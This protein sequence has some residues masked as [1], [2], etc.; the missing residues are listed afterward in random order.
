[1]RLILIHAGDLRAFAMPWSRLL[2][3][4]LVVFHAC[5]VGF[6]VFGLLA[7]LVG[8]VLRRDWVRNFWF[9]MVHLVMIGIVVVESIAGV[10]CPLT[11]WEN[12]LRTN[13]GEAG[14]PG[15]FIGYWAHRLIFFRAEPWMFT[16][17]YVAFGLAV[18]AAFLLAP[19]R[20]PGAGRRTDL[21]GQPPRGPA[22]S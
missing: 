8:I 20:W 4:L 14:Y 17:A 12:Q 10:P 19:P 3:D 16:F 11:L 2:A 9:R 15:D 21:P 1:V 18:A 5:Y 7:I 22:G 6:I 13:A